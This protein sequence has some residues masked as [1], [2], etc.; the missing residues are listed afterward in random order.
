MGIRIKKV[1]GY[2]L[3]DV[4]TENGVITDDRFN[5]EFIDNMFYH[6]DKT[7]EGYFEFAKSQTHKGQFD[8]H[9]ATDISFIGGKAP[10]LDDFLTYDGEGGLPNVLVLTPI[11]GV[12]WKRYDNQI[13]YYDERTRGYWSCE[14]HVEVLTTPLY[15]YDSYINNETGERAN[16]EVRENIYDVR[17]TQ[18]DLK[19]NKNMS[20]EA[21]KGLYDRITLALEDLGCKSH[22]TEKWNVIIPTQIQDYCNYMEMFKDTSTMWKL[23][24][25]IYTYWA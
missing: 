5:Q 1:L 13:D 9:L 12:E 7:I 10:M 22:W 18:L 25:M 24:P 4:K 17:N 15:P 3:V 16:I 8:T 11:T 21:I 2:G 23:Q 14:P 19:Q 6:E 20:P